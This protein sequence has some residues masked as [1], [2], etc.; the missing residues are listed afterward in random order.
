MVQAVGCVDCGKETKR[1]VSSDRHA[2]RCSQ[3]KSHGR[4]QVPLPDRTCPSC[5][6]TYT[7]WQKVQRY[8]SEECGRRL[9]SCEQCGESIVRKHRQGGDTGR[10]CS[11]K[12][13]ALCFAE[14]KRLSPAVLYGRFVVGLSR[15]FLKH[16]CTECKSP[17]WYDYR[18]RTRCLQCGDANRFRNNTPARRSFNEVARQKR[19]ADHGPCVCR[20]CGDIVVIAEGKRRP[21]HCDSCVV[22]FRRNATRPGG[23]TRLEKMYGN[24]GYETFSK[25][26]VFER[27]QWTC[28][29]CGEEV[30]RSHGFPHPRYPTLDHIIP[31]AKGGQHNLA[32]VQC[33]CFGCNSRK[34]DTIY[35]APTV[36]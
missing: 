36:G 9:G 8:C 4:R 26:E 3:C 31:L 17:F 1:F 32:N 35:Y 2:K 13:A 29:V 28:Q 15:R 16:T 22:V 10:F 27:D 34:S 30:T 33:A 11:R 23:G 21:L 18:S 12:C 6:S 14:S 5:K 19:H 25:V 7:P 24:G 20:E